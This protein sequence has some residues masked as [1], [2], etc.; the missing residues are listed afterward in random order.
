MPTAGR[1]PQWPGADGV[2]LALAAVVLVLAAA[3]T[4]EPSALADPRP[5]DVLA[6]ALLAFGAAVVW[7]GGRVPAPAAA[8]AMA[9]T[10]TWYGVGYESGL[11]NVVTL[12]AFYR[13]GRS[14]TGQRV[15]LAVVAASVVA[16]LVM[17][18]GV[19]GEPWL[20]GLTAAGYVLIAVLFGELIRSRHL[21]VGRYAAEAEQAQRDA[22]RRIAE[23]RL[24]IARDVHD[25]LAHTVASMTV[26]AGVAADALDRDPAAAREALA[27]IRRAGRDA[28]GELQA[29]VSV[30]RSGGERPTTAPSP[31]LDR[32]ADVVEGAR[33][34]GVAVSLDVEP[35][36]RPV[37]ELVELTAYRIVQESL[38]NVVRHAEATRAS[39]RVRAGDA[40][41]VV[42]VHDDGRGGPAGVAGFGLRGMAERVDALG[43]E[44]WHGTEP[45]GG[46]TVR[47]RLPLPAVR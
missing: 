22:D 30:L 1:S 18:V 27:H 33:T 32:L 45:D 9:L 37:P 31:R 7:A 43:G 35:P 16:S 14:D 2:L 41:L 15:T 47:A 21:L 3:S 42:E 4:D 24:R 36:T 29:T 6:V 25:L 5:L 8:V 23:E 44:L 13:L 39:V 26:Q 28:T 38:T 46:W 10:F 20:E 40:V 19:G 12:A 34:H 17:I 11:V